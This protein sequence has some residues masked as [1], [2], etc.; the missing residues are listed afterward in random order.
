MTRIPQDKMQD[1]SP[2]DAYLVDS[3]AS[4]DFVLY[5]GCI[6]YPTHESR[7]ARWEFSQGDDETRAVLS[8][9]LDRGLEVA[10]VDFA[11]L[12]DP[13]IVEGTSE[14]C[15]ILVSLLPPDQIFFVSEWQDRLGATAR[16]EFVGGRRSLA[17]P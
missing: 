8:Y 17:T 11:N 12:S 7:V 10:L 16:A 2:E 1:Y 13:S 15:D 9:D 3:Y 14:V 4:R 6:E 5:V